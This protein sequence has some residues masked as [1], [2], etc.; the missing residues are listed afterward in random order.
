MD[1]FLTIMLISAI[2]C[3]NSLAAEPGESLTLVS[4]RKIWDQ[5]P[6]NAFTDLAYWNAQFVCAFREG[7]K[8]VSSDGKIRVLTSHDGNEWKPAALVELTGYDLRDAGLSITPDGRL[9]LIGGA[10]PRKNDN[11]NAPTGSFVSF[12]SDGASVDRAKD[13][14]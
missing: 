11:E 9:M 5:A 1:Y 14:R 7:R 6:H 8:H 12:S 13:C 2:A 3:G 4:T 10:A